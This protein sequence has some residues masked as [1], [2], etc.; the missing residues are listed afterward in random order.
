MF[1]TDGFDSFFFFFQA[2]DGIR[3]WSVTGV[4]TCALPIW[5]RHGAGL[6]QRV[7]RAGA[8][9]PRYLLQDA[10]WPETAGERTARHPVQHVLH[11]PVGARIC[12]NRERRVPR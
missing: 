6:C 8:E 7:L 3:D 11:E 4:Q 9:G 10:A 12:G 5:R 2:E 1:A